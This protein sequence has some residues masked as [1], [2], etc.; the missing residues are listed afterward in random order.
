LDRSR[1]S[2]RSC[3]GCEAVGLDR[4]RDSR[5]SRESEE[6]LFVVFDVREARGEYRGDR[7]DRGIKVVDLIE[8][9]QGIK[10]VIGAVASVCEGR[11]TL[12]ADLRRGEDTQKGAEEEHLLHVGDD[13]IGK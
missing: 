1:D 3:G 7:G 11:P 12:L 9:K 6:V 8:I 2:R 13:G 4:S 5:R 10:D